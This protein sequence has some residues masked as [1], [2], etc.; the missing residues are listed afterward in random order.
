MI[1]S[2]T[3]LLSFGIDTGVKPTWFPLLFIIVVLIILLN[4]FSFMFSP[5]RSW[6]TTTMGRALTSGV[7]PSA[8]RD[9]FMGDGLNSLVYVFVILEQTSCAYTT[10]WHDLGHNC[11]YQKQWTTPV[12]AMIPALIRFV[13]CCRASYD[14]KK[15][16]PQMLNALKYTLSLCTIW[17]AAATRMTGSPIARVAWVCAMVSASTYAS[18]WDIYMDFGLFSSVFTSGKREWLRSELLYPKMFYVSAMMTNT[19]LRA[20]WVITI[21][22][23]EYSVLFDKRVSAF[24]VGMLEILRRFQWNMIRIEYE[25]VKRGPAGRVQEADVSETKQIGS[26]KV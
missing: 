4:P 26:A 18:S 8:F 22:P 1:L 13:Q 10:N 12:V 25:A 17:T 23:N 11:S 15:A 14:S 9:S 5:A 3:A 2:Y 20:A 16:I 7:R 21:S 19:V 24:T 6:L